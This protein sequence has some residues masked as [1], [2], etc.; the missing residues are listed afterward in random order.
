MEASAAMGL[1]E[2]DL[3]ECFDLLAS[4]NRGRLAITYQALPA[5][6]PV[7][8]DYKGDEVV[9][10][11]L[12]GR[13]VLIV[14]PNVGALETGNLGEGQAREWT[15]Q[16]CGFLRAMEPD[17]DVLETLGTSDHKDFFTVTTD[18]VRGWSTL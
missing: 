15:V 17:R 5:I 8:L 11:S 3:S 13:S 14:T 12:L 2:L 9:I 6:V 16:V 18:Q 10:A 7:R 4:A 1:R